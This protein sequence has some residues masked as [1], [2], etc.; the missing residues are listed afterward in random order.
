MD[1]ERVRHI[2]TTNFNMKKSV[3]AKYGPTEPG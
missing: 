1:K 3:C 2:L